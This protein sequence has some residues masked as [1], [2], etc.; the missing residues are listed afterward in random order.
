[1]NL[2]LAKVNFTAAFFYLIQTSSVAVTVNLVILIPWKTSRFVCVSALRVKF[3]QIVCQRQAL[4]Y[5]DKTSPV[6]LGGF[7]LFHDNKTTE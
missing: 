6:Q 3:S 2:V 7:V 1:M 5:H 4:P